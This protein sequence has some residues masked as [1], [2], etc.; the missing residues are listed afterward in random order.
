M[1]IN[2][3]TVTAT[4]VPEPTSSVA[5]VSSLGMAAMMVLRR[6]RRQPD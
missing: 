4:L 5:I 6:R 1:D 2:S 3:V